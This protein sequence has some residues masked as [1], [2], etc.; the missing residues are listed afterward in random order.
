MNI[1]T[2]TLVGIALCLVGMLVG[3]WVNGWRLSGQI[4]AIKHSQT[5]SQLNNVTAVAN[6]LADT[7]GRFVDALQQFQS[8]Q[9][10]N[11]LAQQDLGR[12][13]LD[14]RGVTSGLRGD[15]AGL[16]GRIERASQATLGQYASTCTAVFEAMAAGGAR[17]A[18]AGAGV[19][20]K[21][22]GHSADVRLMQD[23]WTK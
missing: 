18:E 6:D 13:L 7:H 14:L 4:E 23:A 5:Q 9:Q 17:L 2:Q 10:A 12:V 16:P 1:R 19:A 22:D 8:T 15:F 21:A 20:A 11:Q 3:W